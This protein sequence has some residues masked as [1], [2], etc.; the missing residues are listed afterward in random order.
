[1]VLRLVLVIKLLLTLVTVSRECGSEVVLYSTLVL[2]ATGVYTPVTV[3]DATI[4]RGLEEVLSCCPN[5]TVAKA[6]D[7]AMF[8]TNILICEVA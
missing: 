3:L 5:T 6:M 7:R 2:V 8:F 4:I 1:M